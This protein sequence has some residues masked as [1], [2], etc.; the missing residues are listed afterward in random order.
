MITLYCNESC[1]A[2]ELINQWRVSY[3]DDKIAKPG[4]MACTVGE[5]TGAGLHD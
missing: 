1:P 4:Q 3:P 5:I 2:I